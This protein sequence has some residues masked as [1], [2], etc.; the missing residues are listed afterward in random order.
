MFPLSC[1][2]FVARGGGGNYS[3]SAN[4]ERDDHNTRLMQSTE[5]PALYNVA[6]KYTESERM[7]Y[8]VLKCHFV[9]IRMLSRDPA[10]RQCR[11]EQWYIFYL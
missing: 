8:N 1:F 6:Q 10:T 11:I 3:D 5:Y 9:Q 2:L 4:T 7:S